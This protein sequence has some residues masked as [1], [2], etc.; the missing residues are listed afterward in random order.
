MKFNLSPNV[1][2][3]SLAFLTGEVLLSNF[4]DF[5]NK[6]YRDRPHYGGLEEH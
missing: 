6:R 3:E 5:M 4:D 2:S 1:T